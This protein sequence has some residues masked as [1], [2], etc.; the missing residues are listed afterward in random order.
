MKGELFTINKFKLYK[1]RPLSIRL[2]WQYTTLSALR[3]KIV[4]ITCRRHP[5]SWNSTKPKVLF[6]SR[7]LRSINWHEICSVAEKMFSKC[8]DRNTFETCIM[9][10]SVC[11]FECYYIC[12]R[13]VRQKLDISFI[14]AWRKTLAKR[15]QK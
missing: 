1:F 4:P 10:W 8:K 9:Y 15:H 2:G 14:S 3:C 5:L 7:N 11:Q 12:T 6:E 13:L